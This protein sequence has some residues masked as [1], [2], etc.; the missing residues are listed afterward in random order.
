M[1]LTIHNVLTPGWRL[2]R[3]VPLVEFRVSSGVDQIDLGILMNT[4][5]SNPSRGRPNILV[6]DDDDAIRKLIKS[7]LSDIYD[8][9]DTA[10]PKLAL[11]MVFQ[12]P[13]DCILLDLRMPRH[14][15]LELCQTL[16]SLSFTQEIPIF[17][18]SGKSREIYREICLSLGAREF[19][20]KPVDFH[21]LKL[22]IAEALKAATTNRRSEPRLR[23]KTAMV[24][25][26]IDKYGD[27]FQTQITTDNVS[28][29]GFGCLANI[30]MEKGTVVELELGLG[31]ERLVGRARLV[32][33]EQ[34]PQDQMFYGFQIIEKTGN[35]ILE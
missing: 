3:D 35:W 22:C 13:P 17:V 32:R 9:V 25:R 30:A 8:V 31:S 26:G 19:F 2:K 15:G 27:Y 28:A 16:S 33:I 18:I 12:D 7:R 1:P 10:N 23:L 21:R 4:A 5:T 24:L 20:E 11:E 29:S 14:S 34:R 6:V